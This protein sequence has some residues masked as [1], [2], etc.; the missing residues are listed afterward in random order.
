MQKIAHHIAELLFTF[1][2]FYIIEEMVQLIWG[3]TP[4][5]YKVPEILNFPLIEISGMSYPAYSMFR[6]VISLLIFLAIYRVLA[7]T[8]TGLIIKASLTNPNMVA[9]L[10]HNVPRV[11]SN[12]FG[13]GCA[14]ARYEV[15]VENHC[16]QAD[17]MSQ[18]NGAR[19]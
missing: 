16:M 10:G 3:K 6:L 14:L 13:F 12:V 5:P 1:G 11:F 4:V 18:P 8:K 7:K 19:Q 2:L 9:A 17:S 15:L